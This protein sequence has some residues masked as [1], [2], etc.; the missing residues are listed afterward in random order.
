[1]VTFSVY[2]TSDD[3]EKKKLHLEGIIIILSAYAIDISTVSK[4]MRDTYRIYLFD[5]LPL[6]VIH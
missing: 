5:L 4:S 1:M 3:R 2:A 6:P